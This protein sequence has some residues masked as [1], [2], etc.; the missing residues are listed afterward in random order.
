M[1]SSNLTGNAT[2]FATS[3]QEEAISQSVKAMLNLTDG[4]DLADAMKVT[5]LISFFYHLTCLHLLV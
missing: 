5:C 2:S 4:A 3:T 1:E